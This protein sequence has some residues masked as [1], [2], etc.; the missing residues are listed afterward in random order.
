MTAIYYGKSLTNH[1]FITTNNIHSLVK[2]L[3][4]ILP[5][6]LT[7]DIINTIKENNSTVEQYNLYLYANTDT[8]FDDWLYNMRKEGILTY[9]KYNS[10]HIGI[11]EE[12]KLLQYEEEEVNKMIEEK[13]EELIEYL[14][15]V[16]DYEEKEW[17][18]EEKLLYYKQRDVNG[19]ERHRNKLK[20][21]EELE[22]LTNTKYSEK[23]C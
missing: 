5:V 9:P 10:I 12:S 20:E 14:N 21:K 2:D 18:L 13:E 3:P 23:I 6:D 11:D 15:S 17:D 1:V 7:E 19:I 4:P 22:A 8:S 16:K